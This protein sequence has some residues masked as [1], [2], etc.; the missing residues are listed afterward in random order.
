MEL[1]SINYDETRIN[2][3]ENKLELTVMT[4]NIAHGRGLRYHQVNIRNKEELLRNLDGI[5]ETILRENP[6]V[7]G[8]TEMDFKSS[9]NYK[10]DQLDYIAE[11]CGY[12]YT[13][14]VVTHVV[15]VGIYQLKFG[16]AIM[17]KYPIKD[18]TSGYFN[19]KNNRW[20]A[21]RKY[22]IARIDTP[23]GEFDL[24]HVHLSPFSGKKRLMQMTKLSEIAIARDGNL[25][26]LGD[27]NV[28]P[29]YLPMKHDVEAW[30]I[31][32]DTNQFNEFKDDWLS[33]DKLT[34]RSHKPRKI[35]DYIF[36]GKKFE[37]LDYEVI[38][39][40]LSDHR[41]VKSTIIRK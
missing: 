6:D 2:A 8:F 32:M 35:L 33:E 3:T 39:V 12:P 11:K 41:P 17:S 15:H 13:A 21:S 24:V 20:F 22:V 36:V 19:G 40:K 7:V 26:V 1:P 5:S 25:V 37:V 31:L 27:F 29:F 23:V 10:I 4:W 38:K 28:T 34:F 9:W 14:R 30:N 18:V 16:D